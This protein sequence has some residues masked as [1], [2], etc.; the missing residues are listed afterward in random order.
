MRIKLKN[1][2]RK[3]RSY[4][5]ITLSKN[6]NGGEVPDELMSQYFVDNMRLNM[7][8]FINPDTIKFVLDEAGCDVGTSKHSKVNDDEFVKDIHKKTICFKG[9]RTK[10]HYVY[11]CPRGRVTGTYENNLICSGDDG[12]CHGA[13]LAAA[14][15]GCEEHNIGPIYKNPGDDVNKV[16]ENYK[17]IM[18]T[19]LYII[20][21]GWWDKALTR[22]FHSELKWN[23]PKKTYKETIKAKELLNEFLK[24]L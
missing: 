10:G 14:L 18:N 4:G 3:N 6:Q 22:Y 12:I 5:N 23:S 7:W 1:K 15:K 2:T 13:A 11:V 20:N 17:T 9:S 8:Q 21:K 24:T 19:Y 16:K